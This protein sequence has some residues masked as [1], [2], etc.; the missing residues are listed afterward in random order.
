M[1]DTPQTD[2]DGVPATPPSTLDRLLVQIAAQGDFPAVGRFLGEVTSALRLPNVSAQQIANLVLKDFS[3]T[4][5]LLRTV[6]SAF[7]ATPGGR[8]VSTVSNAVVLLGVD[9]V[10]N[11]AVGLRLFDH[12]TGQNALRPVRTMMLQGLLTGVNAR[13]VAQSIAHV[14]PEEAFIAGMMSDLGRLSVAFYLPDAYEELSRRAIADGITLAEAGTLTLGA[15]FDSIGMAVAT[16]WGFPPHICGAIA[17]RSATP[18]TDP[19]DAS[20]QLVVSFARELTTLLARTSDDDRRIHLDALR[21]RF[22]NVLPVRAAQLEQVVI[23]SN[24]RL[25]EL[26]AALHVSARDLAIDAGLPV[27]SAGPPPEPAEL[28]PNQDPTLIL[29][30]L[31]EIS[32]ALS[33][34]H[35]LN[36]VL[37]MVLEAMYRGLGFDHVVLLLASPAHDQLRGRFMLGA[38]VDTVLPQIQVPLGAAGGELARAITA[39]QE[40]LVADVRANPDAVGLPPAV[41]AALAPSAVVAL[42]IVIGSKAIGAI[43][44]DRGPGHPPIDTIDL[45]YLRLLR[46]QAVLAVRLC[47]TG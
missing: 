21:G 27:H 45:R 47:R 12:F 14:V 9:R 36:D 31:E 41:M 8:R 11:L 18:A 44:V 15:D 32:E 40:V 37:M 25:Q 3:L 6:N 16:A 4:N 28:R 34:Q 39:R 22:K 10:A 5:S 19:G 42:P 33:G 46:D 43:Y 26:L 13:G 20:L 17:P 23:E 2:A 38:G 30:A 29:R 35:A 7:F 24:S 1:S